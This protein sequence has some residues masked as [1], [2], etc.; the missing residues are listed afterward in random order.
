[1][2][3]AIY[4]LWCAVYL[5]H[6][7]ILILGMKGLLGPEAKR[8]AKKLSRDI[9]VRPVALV[10]LSFVVGTAIYVLLG[11]GV[12]YWAIRLFF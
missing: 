4:L 11:G 9:R 3:T 2:R 8:A 1:M 7:T 12:V 6:T 5:T 10:A